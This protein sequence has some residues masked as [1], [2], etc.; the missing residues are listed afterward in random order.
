MHVKRFVV[1]GVLACAFSTSGVSARQAGDRL[2]DGTVV[3]FVLPTGTPITTGTSGDFLVFTRRADAVV[4][5]AGTC[6]TGTQLPL[7]SAVAIDPGSGS[8][9]VNVIVTDVNG[10][11]DP[12]PI[13]PGTRLGSLVSLGTC[14]ASGE[15]ELYRGVVE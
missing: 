12:S 1:L 7:Q 5:G 2:P 4:T 6:T 9:H 8:S 13:A 14:G 3:Q 15:F 11:T 10:V